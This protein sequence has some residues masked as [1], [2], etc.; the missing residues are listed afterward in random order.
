MK[1]YGK[2]VETFGMSGRVFTRQF[3]TRET[4]VAHVKAM[5]GTISKYYDGT[6][7]QIVPSR[8]MTWSVG[9]SN[10]QIQYWIY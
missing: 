10:H 1:L 3:Y 2:S 7:E 4:F 8:P 9:N 5:R 6:G